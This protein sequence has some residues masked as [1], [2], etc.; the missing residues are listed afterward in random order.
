MNAVLRNLDSIPWVVGTQEGYR[1]GVT[2]S[3]LV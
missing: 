3:D 1:R 2:W